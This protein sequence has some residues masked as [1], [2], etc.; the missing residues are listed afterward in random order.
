MGRVLKHLL[1]LLLLFVVGAGGA[2][3]WLWFRSDEILRA[4]L[5]KLVNQRLSGA[6]VSIGGARFDFI[7]RIHLYDVALRLS[8]ES[9]PALWIPEVIV[10]L[11]RQQ[12]TDHQRILLQRVQLNQPHLRVERDAEG[13]YAWSRV[14]WQGDADRP[15]LPDLIVSHGEVEYVT[16]S[17][18]ETPAAR[19]L[20]QGVQLQ[21]RPVSRS[22][23]AIEAS[24][25]TDPTGEVVLRG[26][27]P[28]EPASWK[29][30]VEAR[31]LRIERES[32]ALAAALFPPV[33]NHLDA[34]EQRLDEQLAHLGPALA[35]SVDRPRWDFG[36]SVVAKVH[37]HAAQAAPESP[38]EFR[39]AAQIFSGRATHP[40]LP[41]PLSDV[42]A[43]LYADA[44]RIVVR[45]L[46]AAHGDRRLT[47]QLQRERD[48]RMRVR[49]G[50]ERVPVDPALVAR[51]PATL[52]RQVK[53]LG[54]T[55]LLTGQADIAHDGARWSVEAEAALA[56]GT[57]CHEKFPLLVRQV[58]ATASWRD[59]LL[60]IEGAGSSGG[61]P[62]RVV[63]T[64]HDPGPTGSA[65]FHIW[66][67]DFVLNDEIVRACPLALKRTIAE[68]QLTG[69]GNARLRL[70]RPAG[71][72]QKYQLRVW[73]AARKASMVYDQFRY[74]ITELSGE[75]LWDGDQVTF[76]NLRGIHDG[77]VL[78]G[79]GYYELTEPGRLHLEVTA[80]EAA[81]DRDLYAA[82]P[83][84]LREVWDAFAPQGRFS[85]HTV[86]DWTAGREVEVALPQFTLH[87]AHAQLRDF[88]FSWHDVTAELRY[89]R[90]RL[91]IEEF[92]ARHD[93]LH[94][95]GQ[96]VALCPADRPWQVTFSRFH[97]DDLSL[98]PAL[99]RALPGGLRPVVDALNPQ[100][101]FSATG[102]VSFFGPT[103]T[104]PLVGATWDLNVQLA[105]CDITT[106][107]LLRNVHGRVQCSGQFDGHDLRLQGQLD[108]DSLAVLENHQ[109]TAI[110]GP[111]RY[112]DLQLE[113]GSRARTL[114]PRNDDVV[115]V[116]QAASVTGEAYDG[117]VTL[118]AYLD[119]RPE[120][121]AYRAH[122]TLVSANLE[123]YALRH[124]RGQGNVR[125][126]MNGWM[127]LRGRGFSFDRIGGEGQLQI[128]PAA[129]Y[130]L[131]VFL[132]IFQLPQFQPIDRSAFN[133]ANFNFTVVNQRFDFQAID[134][135]GNTL[136]LRGRGYIRFDGL[137][138]L[139]FYTKPP[140][141]QVTVPGVREVV[142][143]VGMLGQ[144]WIAVR[145]YGSVATPV[146]EVVPLP[147]LDDAL[148][149]FLSAFERRPMGPP[150]PIWRG[151]PRASETNSPPRR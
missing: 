65:D 39:V 87:R 71:L 58:S 85:L 100:G 95:S 1:F 150:P 80:K 81:F 44:E 60:R 34:V 93:E 62:I 125:G 21:A 92:S 53:S 136:S 59:N 10:T 134:L 55:G 73:A 28:L 120:E 22:S 142:G 41:F 15:P 18:A 17:A 101:R 110:R 151:P 146:A 47:I 63:G 108:L 31:Q 72:N 102:P 52:Q 115:Q 91:E 117:E 7:G 131:P 67:D 35:P 14:R 105:G 109:V 54:L 124:L 130:E 56:D 43:V 129:L 45:D 138:N 4:E 37:L 83:A 98:T 149:Q 12:F 9:P 94:I 2:A 112:Q 20:V 29:L 5:L 82:L 25:R 70:Q 143:L 48:G 8:E 11:D 61:T 106:G 74:P 99:R 103:R 30:A 66:A 6:A 119:L 40:A 36:V 132:Q 116:T 122:L 77:A 19:L 147:V 107:L 141:N 128:S 24:A 33:A 114:P 27:L 148:K 111:F 57:V 38:P 76:E 123:K 135:V 97:V 42:Q 68:L 140:R 3:A 126:L 13:Q 86:I 84:A 69:R 113:V 121:P 79:R 89:A 118:D 88:P 104:R 23:Y 50:V 46:E 51:L 75:A 90:G 145:V 64:L 49:A 137:V 96:G 26:Q 144:G 133:Y 16:Q 139:Y 127:D 32:L 78:T